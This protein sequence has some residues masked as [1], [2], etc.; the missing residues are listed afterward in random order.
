LASPMSFKLGVFR[1]A[2]RKA[3]P[4]GD[5]GDAETF[6]SVLQR[7][8]G[9]TICRDFYFPYAVKIWGRPPQELSA[10]QARRGVA[11][12]S[13]GKMVRKILRAVPGFKP[14][15]AGRFFYP[16]EGYGQISR[17]IGAAASQRGA[18]FE[19]GTRVTA[20]RLGRPHRIEF[21][22]DGATHMLE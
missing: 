2:I 4:A 22:H 3:L 8:L 7:G 1:D 17:A 16:R 21:Q 12:G 5:D 14:K 20:L 10:I 11:A 6:A 13:L 15:G 18:R 9:L 19:F